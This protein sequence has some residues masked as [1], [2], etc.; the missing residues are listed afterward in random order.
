MGFSSPIQDITFGVPQG[1]I[2]GPLLFLLYINDICS[3]ITENI[4]LKLFADD[5]AIL[6]SHTDLNTLNTIANKTMN[7]VIHWLNMNKLS[8]NSDKTFGIFFNAN[9][10]SNRNI[11]NNFYH[12][13]ISLQ[14]SQLKFVDHMKYLGFLIDSKLSFKQ[15]VNYLKN[16]LRKWIP[17][18]G[19]VGPLLTTFAKNTLYNSLFY[20]NIL[21]GIELYGN[22][23]KSNIQSLQVIQNKAL[24]ALYGYNRHS[25]TKKLYMELGFNDISSVF[26]IRAS[27]L[28][29]RLLEETESLN[30]HHIVK[31]YCNFAEHKYSL[32]D[33]K[34]ISLKFEKPSFTS[35]NT[36]KLFLLWNSLPMQIRNVKSF[37]LFNVNIKNHLKI[38]L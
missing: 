14:N 30:V 2:L 32:R 16:K 9:K 1:S 17:I 15:H 35:S 34:A 18:F 31:S 22:T 7:D 13:Q 12:P 38:K 21:Y 5:T 24:K 28:L 6:I 29:K 20:S 33:K 37:R 23:S 26:K 19:K 36:F 10:K 4:D 25:T 11:V 3:T 27:I 8:L